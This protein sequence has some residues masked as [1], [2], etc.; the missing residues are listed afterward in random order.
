MNTSVP[1]NVPAAVPP[2]PSRLDEV[3]R[4]ARTDAATRPEIHITFDVEGGHRDERYEFRFRASGSGEVETELRDNLRGL[5]K[6]RTISKLKS[7]ELAD[8]LTV[9]DV[10]RLVRASRLQQRIPPG[11][12]VGRLEVRAAG[13]VITVVFMADPGQAR[14]AGYELPEGVAEIM[15]RILEI[16]AKAMGLDDVRPWAVDER[17]GKQP[18]RG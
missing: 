3:V 7:R 15:E 11:S 5:A 4:R 17:G 6:E 18:W 13:Q 1:K 2:A 12:V 8:L 16:G 14:S 9:I 10:P